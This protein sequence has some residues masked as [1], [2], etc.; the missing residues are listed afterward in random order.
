MINNLGSKETVSALMPYSG[1]GYPGNGKWRIYVSGVVW[2]TPVVFNRRQRMMIRMLGG[3]MQ[4]TPD[5]INGE[6]FQTRIRPFMAEAEHRQ[7]ILVNVNGS[8]YRLKRKTRRNGHFHDCLTVDPSDI[9]A[10]T[11]E[12]NG[13]QMVP[14]TFSIEDQDMEPVTGSVFLHPP[15]GISV[16]SDIDDTIKDTAVG[17]RR[18]L[19]ANTF[20]REF[21]SIEGMADVYQDWATGGA[22]FHY[23]SSSPWQLYR[24]LQQLQMAHGFPVGTMHLRNFRLRDQLLKRVIIRRK[25]KATAIRLLMESMP[26]RDFV[27]IGDSG[28]K[29]PKIYRKIAR[30]FGDRIKGVFIR[31]VDH[32]PLDQEQFQKLAESATGGYCARFSTAE[33]LREHADCVF[34]G[35]K[36]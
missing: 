16:I 7:S 11:I 20:L 25:G 21:R 28:E 9:E 15:E 34:S 14:V 24:S 23:V 19:L 1:F 5:E 18:E 22:S 6:V 12:S 17:D 33:Q 36:C 8:S 4:A 32:R 35:V 30:Q 26:G 2:Q 13:R 10:S 3:V 29:D 27:L 31:D